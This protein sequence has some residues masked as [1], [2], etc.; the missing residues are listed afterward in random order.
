MSE[1][2]NAI[3]DEAF[4][5]NP[6]NEELLQ[7]QLSRLYDTE[8]IWNKYTRMITDLLQVQQVSTAD[9]CFRMLLRICF[10]QDS[11]KALQ[12]ETRQYKSL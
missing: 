9:R 5:R 3:V 7:E 8:D 6:L 12:N 10:R 4:K 2:F 1:H 11:A